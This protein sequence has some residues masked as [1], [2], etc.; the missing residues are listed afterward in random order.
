VVVPVYNQEAIL[1]L[2]LPSLLALEG[3]R[4]IV[5]VDDGS[6]DG[7]AALLAIA[8]REREDVRVVTHP[9]NR[10]RSAARNTGIEATTGSIVLFLDADIEPA[11]GLVS[12]HLRRY[13]DPSVVGVLSRD[14]PRGLMDGDPFHR[15]LC[16]QAGPRSTSATEPLHFKFF[17]IG[18]TS[19]RRTALSAVGG[20]DEAIRYGEDLD[21]AYRISTRWP[22]GL[23]IEPNALVHQH[24]LTELDDRFAKLREFGRNLPALLTKHPDLAA[25]ADLMVVV[26]PTTRWILLPALASLA[27][28]MMPAVPKRLQHVFIRHVLAS[29]VATGYREASSL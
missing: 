20:F 8:A 17:I 26:S 14:E 25:A 13:A 27:R 29:A 15:Y 4:E 19:I 2:T 9:A 12:A 24:G 18:Y 6:T 23:R 11:G 1:P 7:S 16:E 21:L 22:E 3:H 5:F 10:G 28:R